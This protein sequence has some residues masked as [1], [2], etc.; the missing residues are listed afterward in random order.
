LS[1]GEISWMLVVWSA[2]GFLLEIPTGALA[3]RFSRRHLLALAQVLRAAA[4]L[5]WWLAPGFVGF[6]VGFALWGAESALASG[7]FQALVFDELDAEG[8]SDEYARL[9]GRGEAWS[10]A[11]A[12]VGS[13]LAAAV[14]PFGFGP[15][16]AASAFVSLVAGAIALSFPVARPAMDLDGERYVDALRAG[17]SEVVHSRSLLVFVLFAGIVVGFGAIEEFQALLLRDVGIDRTGISLWHAAFFVATL[18]GSLLARHTTNMSARALAG[19]ALAMG[20]ALVTI[21]PAPPVAVP[22]SILAF[23]GLYALLYVALDARLQH[24][25]SSRARATVTSVQSFVV[26]VVAIG[27]F[28]GFGA[29]ASASSRLTAAA[30]SGGVLVAV[31]AAFAA[32]TARYDVSRRRR[33]V[34]PRPLVGSGWFRGWAARMRPTA[35]RR[36]RR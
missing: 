1:T 4:F 17:V 28:L 18:G 36:R 5:V 32:T 30:I 16:L 35:P 8:R 2:T 27:T 21:A 13:L 24:L 19:L 6:A 7:A 12:V 25:I 9:M 11:G 23:E 31:A 33:R 14:I 26:E 10:S 34:V 22:M 29:I 3:D 20:L 15:V